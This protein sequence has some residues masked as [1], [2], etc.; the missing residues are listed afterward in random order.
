VTSTTALCGGSA[1]A[2]CGGTS[3][4][5]P[6]GDEGKCV[7]YCAVGRPHRASYNSRPMVIALFVKRVFIVFTLSFAEI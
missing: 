2:S 7:E 1:G 5:L 4:S 3:S 6:P